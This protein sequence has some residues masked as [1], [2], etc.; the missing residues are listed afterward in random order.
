MYDK[1]ALVDLVKAK[2]LEFGD[3]TLASGRK[4]NFYL[5][6][7]RITLD[8]VGANLVAEGI[9]ELLG[10]DLP[11]AIG[12]MAIGADPITAA[13]I[14]LAGQRDLALQGFIVRAHMVA[15]RT[16]A[17]VFDPNQVD[18]ESA[19][20]AGG[21]SID[22]GRNG[23]LRAAVQHQHL[24]PMPWGGPLPRIHPGRVVTHRMVAASYVYSTRSRKGDPYEFDWARAGLPDNSSHVD[25]DVLLCRV[26][27]CR[28]R[29]WADRVTEGQTQAARL[30]RNM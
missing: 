26:N 12:G 10:S 9:L 23:G 19:E 4:A 30:L 15:Q 5:D 18:A 16:A 14:T 17:A 6:C 24:S 28:D 29:R 7:R 21:G 13:V 11:D 20:Y 8:S 3:F 1:N 25:Q 2:A 22:V 27:L